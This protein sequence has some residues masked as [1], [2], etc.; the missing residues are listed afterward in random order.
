LRIKAGSAAIHAGEFLPGFNNEYDGKAP[1]LG[2]YEFGA[3]L[4]QYGPRGK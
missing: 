4:P 3:E 1:D 2:A